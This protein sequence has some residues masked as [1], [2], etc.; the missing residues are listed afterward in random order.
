MSHKLE[1]MKKNAS[2][3]GIAGIKKDLIKILDAELH[4]KGVDDLDTK[5]CG[6]VTDM[7]KDLAEA[8][9]NCLEACYYEKIIKAMEKAEEE[10]D[11]DERMGYNSRRYSNGR[12]APKGR[13]TRMG[14]IPHLEDR[15]WIDA[16]LH[17]PDFEP[18]MMGYQQGAR[19]NQS[20]S[21]SDYGNSG[22]RNQSGSRMGYDDPD[23]DPQHSMT[24]NE[25]RKARR[26]YMESKN[27]VDKQTMEEKGRRHA[28]EAMDTIKDIWKDADPTL[29]KELKASMQQALN[30][31][32]T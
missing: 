29:R 31:M 32:P 7:I 2:Y 12:Y 10:D 14:Y 11:D 23:M 26:H 4:M 19:R 22:G 27:P 25:Y 17:N 24:Y 20:G 1:E 8:E 9:K 3:D 15:P 5:D 6:E 13:G 16:Y 18:E 21:S 30:E 28:H